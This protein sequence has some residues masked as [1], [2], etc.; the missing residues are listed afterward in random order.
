MLFKRRQP[1]STSSH[2]VNVRQVNVICHASGQVADRRTSISQ[3][4]PVVP[5]SLALS[6]VEEGSRAPSD[7]FVPADGCAMRGGG[8]GGRDSAPTLTYVCTTDAVQRSR[9][10]TECQVRPSCRPNHDTVAGAGA[11]AAGAALICPDPQTTAEHLSSIDL[12][13]SAAAGRL[14]GPWRCGGPLRRRLTRLQR[15]SQHLQDVTGSGV[16]QSKR[17]WSSQCA[18]CRRPSAAVLQSPGP[19]CCS[20]RPPLQKHCIGSHSR[21]SMAPPAISHTPIPHPS[22]FHVVSSCS[23]GGKAGRL[24]SFSNGARWCAGQATDPLWPT[25]G[26][27]DPRGPRYST[28]GRGLGCGRP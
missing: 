20:S 11:R 1:P 28:L 15:P 3:M 24:D 5:S 21:D 22:V 10:G 25:G 17:I 12:A 2:T 6:Q 7:G 19:V 4:S 13:R 16:F 26:R 18:C 14:A 9:C 8:G 23:L 27:S